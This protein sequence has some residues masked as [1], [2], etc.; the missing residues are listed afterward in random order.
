MDIS[1]IGS[2]EI[3]DDQKQISRRMTKTLDRLSSG[4]NVSSVEQDPILWNDLQGLKSA[5]SRLN[6]YSDNLNRGAASVRIAIET[7]E[8][9]DNHLLELGIV[10][11]EALEEKE[12]SEA[13][14]EH[15]EQFNHLHGLLDDLAS[16][17]DLG[18]RKLLDDP[19]RFNAAGPVH[20]A[21]GEDDFE[22]I[23]KNQPIH[24]GADG[25]DLPMI[26]DPLPS[27]P[28]GSPIVADIENATEEEIRALMDRLSFARE[29]LAHKT[30]AL[31]VDAQAIQF[32]TEA[33]EAFIERNESEE[34]E[35]NL[36]DL[37]AEAVLAQAL[38]IRT[39]LATYGLSGFEETKRLALSLLQ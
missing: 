4:S 1:Q 14:T 17:R 22:I 8:V 36:P 26:G 19:V 16:P 27:D 13:R 38:N 10:L 31:S 30:S 18:A 33:N 21:A 15:L 12:G 5:V 25:L 7:M 11:E 9:S 39:N 29:Q 28:M 2:L 23:L 20:I 32:S 24:T 6:A 35:L 3:L 37:E 34:S